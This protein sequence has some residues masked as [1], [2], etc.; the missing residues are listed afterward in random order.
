[1]QNELFIELFS[2]E[3][4]ARMQ[5]AAAQ[6][7]QQNI[8]NV[9]SDTGLTYS[10]TINHVTCQRVVVV[11][12]GLVDK[13]PNQQIDKRGPKIGA[14]EQAIN[15]FCK[16]N[17]ITASNLVEE[18]GYYYY[19]ANNPGQPTTQILPQLLQ[20]AIMAYTWPKSML[21]GSYDLRWVR[22]LKSII[23]LYNA[24]IIPLQLGHI[25]ASNTTTGHRFLSP[26]TI[27]VNNFAD[28]QDKLTKANVVLDAAQRK[29]T[30]LQQAQELAQS[31]GYTLIED[32]SLLDETAGLAEYPV[33][34]HGNI[35]NQFM[36]VPKEVLITS[37]KSHQKYFSALDKQGNLAPIFIF[38][39]N[40]K[41]TD[42]VIKG[43]EK[44]LRARLSDAKF[45]WEQDK[46]QP[47]E[48][49]L[50]KLANIV[51]HAKIGTVAKRVKRIEVLAQQ[52][53]KT[54]GADVTQ[55]KRAAQLC[56]ADLVSNMVDEFASLQGIMG[57]YYAA[58]AGE[59]EQV[60]QAIAQHYQPQG[61]N[62]NVPTAPI[63]IALA[64]ADKLDTLIE[65]FKIGERPTG[66]KDPYALRRNALG[67]IR[68]ILTNNLKINLAEFV[69]GEVLEFINERLKH[70]L[71]SQNI[72]ADVINAIGAGDDVLATANKA[73]ILNSF[74]ITDAGQGLLQAY[75]RASNI[76]TVE[77]K[78]DGV[79]YNAQPDT[80]AFE[81]D[82]DNELF[83]AIISAQTNIES[84]ISTDNYTQAIDTLSALEPTVTKFFDNVM[85]NA[86]NTD[87]RIARLNL[88]GM[89]INTV[90]KVA[91]F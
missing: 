33:V 69:N 28:Y 85:V 87:T 10:N 5:A 37:M 84:S 42:E 53:A 7:I 3:I 31:K 78:K 21:W 55:T 47:L 51:Y 56:K 13:Q 74:I 76:L 73:N 88:L 48:A 45:F 16:S 82:E 44:V 68:L 17:N 49:N 39:S 24:T 63:S 83:K 9:L 72:V 27:E 90:G 36:D 2:E 67:V 66:S 62:D 43:N 18:G 4:P 91:R 79:E 81:R 80:K 14:P 77:Q 15:G 11:I 52:V 8:T 12:E 23:C 34:L 50:P 61:A 30:I 60:A 20:Q 75:K 89:F 54:I 70:L 19:R 86:D 29:A 1:M 38:V 26:N 25:K 35:D 58:H 6:A 22:P 40:I 32:A 57:G 59:P 65:L 71:R 64:M 46:K 41:A